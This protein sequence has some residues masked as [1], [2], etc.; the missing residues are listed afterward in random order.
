MLILKG[1]C[2]KARV[3]DLLMDKTHSV[4]FV[5]NNY[6]LMPGSICVDSTQHS[7]DDFIECIS[8]E[9]KEAIIHDIDYHYLLVYTNKLENEIRT[10]IDWINKY[11]F[12]IPCRDIILTCK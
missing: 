1:E 10:L 2:G 5:Y 11:R 8:E 3:V 6:P 9:M 7:L 12:K 4:C